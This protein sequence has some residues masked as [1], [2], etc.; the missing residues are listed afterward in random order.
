MSKAEVQ[1]LWGAP[2]KKAAAPSP[3]KPPTAAARGAA[4]AAPP[5]PAASR[6]IAQVAPSQTALG[7]VIGPRP[8]SGPM[9]EPARDDQLA[10][11]LHEAYVDPP[12]PMSFVPNRFAPWRI[13]EGNLSDKISQGSGGMPPRLKAR[14]DTK[15]RLEEI[16]KAQVDGPIAAAKLAQKSAPKA[17]ITFNFASTNGH[18]EDYSITSIKIEGRSMTGKVRERRAT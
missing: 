3:A 7:T 8:T 14:L 15:R 2:V 6:A 5:Q 11:I 1:A 17:A 9:S 13:H 12:G 16:A 4:A 18:A 10:K